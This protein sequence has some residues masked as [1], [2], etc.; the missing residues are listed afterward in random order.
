MRGEVEVKGRRRER[1]ERRNAYGPALIKLFLP[2]F[3]PITKKNFRK[4]VG[5]IDII[6]IIKVLINIKHKQL[7]Y[8]QDFQSFRIQ[9]AFYKMWCVS[10]KIKKV[11]NM[12]NEQLK[13]ENK[14]YETK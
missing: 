14:E 6:L 12:L 1:E 8:T 3:S 4:F 11:V 2:M 9:P 10:L 13:T 7:V 5:M